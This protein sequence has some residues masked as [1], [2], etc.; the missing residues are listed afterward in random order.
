M[1]GRILIVEDEPIVALDLKLVL[2][3]NGHKVVGIADCADAAFQLTL[4]AAP[5]LALMDVNIKG[6]MNGIETARILRERY[7]VPAVFLTAYSDEPTLTKAAEQMPLGYLIKPFSENEVKAAIHIG[8]HKRTKDAE[9]HLQATRDSLTGL[10]NRATILDFFEK[11]LDRAARLQSNTGFLMID[12]DHFK[13]IN[14]TYGHLAGDKVLFEVANRLKNAVRSYDFVG[15][16][17]G[18]EFCAVLPNCQRHDLHA[19]ADL[20]RK[21][22]SEEPVWFENTKI[23]VTASIGSTVV[24]AHAWS[25]TT[26]IATADVAL[27]RAKNL[28]RNRAVCCLQ[29]ISKGSSTSSLRAFE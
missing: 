13:D 26:T 5:E 8:L 11:E 7:N 28:G 2:E 14:D 15:R 25:T 3:Q 4:E 20:I 21:A 27:Y 24:K 18:D 19:R 23:R 22:L 17:G 6:S 12:V 1:I 16:Y 9:L 10:L 29:C